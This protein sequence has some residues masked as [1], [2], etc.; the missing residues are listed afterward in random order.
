MLLHI[1]IHSECFLSPIT[2]T[3]MA[4][5]KVRVKGEND[6]SVLVRSC[7]CETPESSYSHQQ[8]SVNF[9]IKP[10][11]FQK[12]ST[13]NWWILEL[14]D[15]VSTHSLKE[16]TGKLL[17]TP[18]LREDLH[19]PGYSFRVCELFIA[20]ELAE[21]YFLVLRICYPYTLQYFLCI[22]AGL[23][24]PWDQREIKLEKLHLFA[25]WPHKLNLL[26]WWNEAEPYGRFR[27]CLQPTFCLWKKL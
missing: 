8:V 9:Q 22:I 15:A 2:G 18:L 7:N 23:I 25:Y 14:W 24:S 13:T 19:V 5:K 11:G 4:L 27:P 17:W 6:M 12:V 3:L 10:D 21:I 26:S 1:Y 20:Q 16:V